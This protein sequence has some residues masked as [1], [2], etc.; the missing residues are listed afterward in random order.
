MP[1]KLP[2]ARARREA[3]PNLGARTIHRS[4]TAGQQGILSPARACPFGMPETERTSIER[5]RWIGAT[6]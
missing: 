3:L 5:H 2:A 6:G 1:S 4:V